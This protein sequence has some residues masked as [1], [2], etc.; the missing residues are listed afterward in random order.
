MLRNRISNIIFDFMWKWEYFYKEE[1]NVTLAMQT[2]RFRNR[3]HAIHVN[4]DD[5]C[6]P[7]R[8]ERLNDLDAILALID[9]GEWGQAAAIMELPSSVPLA[10]ASQFV[11][12]L[13]K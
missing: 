8:G 4:N 13:N 6:W 7:L 11:I 5:E 9:E 2:R 3:V 10:A 1:V 12:N